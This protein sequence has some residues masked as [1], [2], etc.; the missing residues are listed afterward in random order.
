M[1][2]VVEQRGVFSTSKSRENGLPGEPNFNQ[3]KPQ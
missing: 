2:L 3:L 1:I